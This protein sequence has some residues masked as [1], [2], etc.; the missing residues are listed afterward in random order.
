MII[1]AKYTGKCRKCGGSVRVGEQVD[2]ENRQVAHLTGGC[3]PQAPTLNTPV[4]AK[5]WD[6]PL[7]PCVATGKYTAVF[8]GDDDYETIRVKMPGS[9]SAFAGR[10]M[11]CLRSGQSFEA[12]AFLNGDQVSVWQKRFANDPRVPRA[13]AAFDVIK[14]DPAAAG[15]AY[16]LR[17]SRCYRC[18]RDL[19]VPASIHRGLGPDCAKA[20]AA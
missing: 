4:P 1:R 13:L 7:A 11:L 16:A 9:E 3:L 10:A 18:D 14:A 6:A 2:W 20:V 17:S 8:N 5:T 12:F 19:T 15:L